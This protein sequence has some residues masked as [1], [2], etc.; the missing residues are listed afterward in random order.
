MILPKLLVATIFLLALHP[1]QTTSSTD[2]KVLKSP[3]GEY[4][5]TIVPEQERGVGPGLYEMRRNGQ[6]VWQG[7]R[8][9]FL[10]GAVVGNVG[11]VIGFSLPAGLH[12]MTDVKDELHI[13]HIDATGAA[14]KLKSYE[15]HFW[16]FDA[17]S[18]PNGGDVQIYEPSGIAMVPISGLMES[19]TPQGSKFL[20]FK[21][22][23]G[24][25]AGS[26]EPS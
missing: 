21:L 20:F 25:E 11:G 14:K 13:W 16:A 17:P 24:A 10:R 22:S 18:A 5:L 15:R 19:Y 12:H 23:N 7:E 8:P 9:F 26:W 3:S 1:Q 6:I 2:R 4:E